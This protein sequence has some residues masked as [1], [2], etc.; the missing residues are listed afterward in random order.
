M[1]LIVNRSPLQV[2]CHP[3]VNVGF[4]AIDSL[5]QL[6]M[7][8]LDKEELPHFQFQKDF[9]KPFAYILANNP[10]IAIKD[11]VSYCFW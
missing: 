3:N 4:F 9:L 11:M 2:G 5:R 1:C 8:F 10:N 7:Q 6:S